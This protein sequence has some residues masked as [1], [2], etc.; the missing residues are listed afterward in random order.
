V[1]TEILLFFLLMAGNEGFQQL[2]LR[3]EHA[4]VVAS[5]E[6]L[7]QCRTAL[8]AMLEGNSSSETKQARYAI[9]YVDWRLY[10]L[11][12]SHAES[13]KRGEIYVR[14]AEVQLKELIKED[15]KNAEANALL[16]TVYGQQIAAS[17]W[18]GM[19]LGPKSSAY[20]KA[21]MEVAN[22][23]P[24][25]VLQL[26]VGEMHTPKMFGGGLEKAERDLRRAELLFSWE[27]TN[28]AWPNWGRL[29]VL[30]WMGQ[31]LALKGDRQGAR[32]YYERAL[33]IEPDYAWVRN[34]LLPALDK[35]ASKK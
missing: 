6:Q 3:M 20:I 35:P 16:S 31:L 29:E 28:L 24:R 2:A 17:P 9:A 21:A 18:K 34:I 12:S 19:I 5:V 22:D 15:S 26:G 14:E 7:E 33:A 30:A 25:M 13:K 10:S 32:A 23:N 11:L 27:P 8:M 4:Q 1:L